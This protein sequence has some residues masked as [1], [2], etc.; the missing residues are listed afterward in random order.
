MTKA[1]YG[2]GKLSFTL[3]TQKNVL[4][5]ADS[6]FLSILIL[7]IMLAAV[8]ITVA[9]SVSHTRFQLA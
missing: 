5:T 8:I 3:Y 6:L 1:I 4:V 2:A 9:C 7:F